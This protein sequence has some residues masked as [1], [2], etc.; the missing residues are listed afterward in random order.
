MCSLLKSGKLLQL[1]RSIRVSAL[2]SN[3]SF[4]PQNVSIQELRIQCERRTACAVIL[5]MARPGAMAAA[6]LLAHGRRP[7]TLNSYEGK[8]DRFFRFCNDVQASQGFP[9][10][11]PMPETSSSFASLPWLAAG[12]GQG[13]C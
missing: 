5:D 1:M 9:A 10:L 8:F 11:S 12:G 4:F 2:A 3:S 7:G 13:P 6:H